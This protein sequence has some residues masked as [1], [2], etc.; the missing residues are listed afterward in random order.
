MPSRRNTAPGV[1][2]LGPSFR[3]VERAGS[4]M[5][6]EGHRPGLTHSAVK[7]LPVPLKTFSSRVPMSRACCALIAYISQPKGGCMFRI[8]V[9]VCAFLLL[10][11]FVLPMPAQQPVEPAVMSTGTENHITTPAAKLTD[12]NGTGKTK[13]REGHVNESRSE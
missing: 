1:S 6:G 2:I 4:V 3:F 10:A 7:S 13:S 5:L 9:C 8:S 12:P 11:C